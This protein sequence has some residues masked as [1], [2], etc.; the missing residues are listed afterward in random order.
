MPDWTYQTVF[1]PTLMG[2]GPEIGRRFAFG[3]MGTL[4][5]LPWGKK[6]I[7][8]MG[9]M[10]PDSRLKIE[11]S[12]L[13]FPTRVGLGCALDPHLLATP[14]F[15]EF[16]LGFLEIGPVSINPQVTPG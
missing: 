9:H 1:R 15:G 12:G 2:L 5:R 7:Q 13:T 8:F 11:H 16:G 10:Q 3:F 6:I 4:A 14:A